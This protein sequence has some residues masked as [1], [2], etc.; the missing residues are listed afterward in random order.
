MLMAVVMA[1]NSFMSVML[2]YCSAQRRRKLLSKQ[3]QL[4][5]PRTFR[6]HPVPVSFHMICRILVRTYLTVVY[7]G[8]DIISFSV[9]MSAVSPL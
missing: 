7:V 8:G 9:S 1:V 6:G 4:K 5:F 3:M 2:V